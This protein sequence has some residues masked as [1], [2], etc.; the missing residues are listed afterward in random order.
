[1]EIA[2][3]RAQ[4]KRW[5]VYSRIVLLAFLIL[6]FWTFGYVLQQSNYDKAYLSLSGD[7]KVL[8]Q[9]ISK[10]AGEAVLNETKFA[11]ELLD[12]RTKEFDDIIR[13]L[14][15]GGQFEKGDIVLPPTPEKIQNA[16]LVDVINF[17]H[18]QKEDVIVILNNKDSILSLENTRQEMKRLLLRIQNGYVDIVNILETSNSSV[19]KASPFIKQLIT[20]LSIHDDLMSILS[21][22]NDATLIAQALKP[23][24]LNFQTANENA[25]QTYQDIALQQK[26]TSI[27]GDIDTLVSK[28]DG[29]IQIAVPMS[30]VNAAWT[31]LFANGPAFLAVTT[32]LESAYANGSSTRLVNQWTSITLICID[33]II[34]LFNLIFLYREKQYSLQESNNVKES[35]K[36]EIQTLV[37]DL[38]DLAHGNL[39]VQAS[40]HAGETNAIA[41]AI[42]YAINA[43]RNLVVT[44]NE[45]TQQLSSSAMDVKKISETLAQGS[46]YQ[47][48]EI[49]DTTSSVNK[50]ASSIDQVSA[51]ALQSAGVAETSVAIAHEGVVVVQNTISGMERIR[52]QIQET[53]KRVRRLGESS[54]EIG[55][56]VSL[57]TGIAEQTNI[58]S[59]NAAIQAAMAGEAG[60]GFAVV[61]DEVQR[62][63]EKSGQATK[64]VETLVKTIQADTNQAINSMEKA[65]TE[66]IAGTKLAN[67]AGVALGKIET[68]S[69]QL[70]EL[71]QNI[72]VAAQEQALVSGSISKT[73]AVIEEIARQTAAGTLQSTESVGELV[74]LVSELRNSVAEF[75]LPSKSYGK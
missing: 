67:D 30:Q 45:T 66:V 40:A 5:L 33:L 49:V 6:T 44:I 74:T 16:E 68:V 26:L 59:L 10:D 25:L 13:L 75:K 32:Q 53:E 55:E 7:L 56:I 35:L 62:L 54:Q 11:F 20:T 22:S 58:L 72:S 17:W 39:A 50:M 64:E 19:N 4:Y 23:K 21:A 34:V 60:K 9:K 12:R 46:E 43:L 27:R 18:K 29:I 24:V 70:A 14:K 15:Q 2:E 47:A 63:A 28:T 57:I 71:I 69:L 48:K 42:N 38:S 31:D 52:G 41:E 51:H 61:A 73:M 1:M 36:T 8:T 65:I 37:S 3:K